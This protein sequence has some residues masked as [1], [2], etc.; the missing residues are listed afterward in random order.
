MQ[1]LCIQ[2]GMTA[3]ILSC[4]HYDCPRVTTLRFSCLFPAKNND[5]LLNTKNM[6]V[7]NRDLQQDPELGSIWH[8]DSI[9]DKPGIS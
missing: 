8:F 1:V 9:L 4:R 6:S 5:E 3:A 2:L 7:A